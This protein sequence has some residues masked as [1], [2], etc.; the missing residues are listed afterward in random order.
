MIKPPKLQYGD[1]IG[2]VAPC[3]K[4]NRDKMEE[5]IAALQ[6][7]GFQVKKAA[8]LYSE[9]WSFAGSLEERVE[10]FNTM[11]ADDDVRM[12]FFGGGEV[13]NELLPYLDYGTLQRRPKI[14]CS[15]SDSTTLLNA[16]NCMS[17][18]VTFYGASP[19]TFAVLN[20]Y[21]RKSFAARLMEGS[22]TYTKAMPWRTICPGH[23]EGVLTGGYL[24]N[25]AL[26]YG[27]TYYPQMPYEKCLL[28]IE[29][30]EMF[31][32]PSIVSKY[33]ANLEHRGVLERATG[34]IFGHYS[35]EASPVIDDI[36]FRV[37]EKHGIPV[38]RCEDFG[39]GVYNAVL[40]IG[41]TAEL[42]TDT[43]QLAFLEAGVV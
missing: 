43:N 35:V 4:V 41:V 11:I 34:L 13:C 23:C 36:L 9:A 19:R 1:T 30:H 7:T 22:L 29:D 32:V 15:Y 16:I 5:S 10:D 38:V 17:G 8:H 40:P 6:A 18:L 42:D 26:L 28:F 20:D 21:N 24:A 2:I 14:V 25:Y 31:S 27:L 12:I 37:G 33:F 3:L 39:H